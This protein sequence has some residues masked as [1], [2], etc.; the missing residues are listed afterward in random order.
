MADNS[1]MTAAPLLHRLREETANDHAALEGALALLAPPL[2]RERF[3]AA[4]QGFHRFHAA[5]EPKV[6][7]LI[8]RPDLLAARTRLA[9]IEADLAALDAA[10][11]DG[12]APDL[13]ALRGAAEGW[14]SLYVM[15]GSTLGGLVIA[16]ALRDAPWAPA[17]GLAYFH[18]HGRETAAVWRETCA[19]L[20]AAG[21]TLDP[22]RIV[23]GARATFASLGAAAA[24][25]RAD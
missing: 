7:A 23:A 5:W 22:E 3:V 16:K 15:E 14:G 12:P 6:A 13:D 17:A 20:E 4:L 11:A 18:A 24:P 1:G 9:L 10:P 8:D 21:E 2:A 25:S 19:A